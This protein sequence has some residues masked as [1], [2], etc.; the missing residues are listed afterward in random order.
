MASHLPGLLSVV[1][2]K[3]VQG[4]GGFGGSSKPTAVM[5]TLQVGILMGRRG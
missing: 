3:R 5:D 1:G 2:V 4:L